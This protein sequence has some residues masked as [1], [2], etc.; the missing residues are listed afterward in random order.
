M[1]TA[2]Y[3]GNV[4]SIG[5]IP[6]NEKIKIELH[7]VHETLLLPLWSRARAAELNCSFLNDTQAGQ[8]IERLDYDFSKFSSKIRKFFIVMLA[9]RAKELDGMVCR[10]IQIHPRAT[11]VNIGA[12]LDTTFYRINNG[13]I[14][15]YDLDVPGVID[16]RQALLEYSPQIHPIPKSMFDPSFLDD[17]ESQKDGILFLVSGVLM[18]FSEQEVQSFLGAIASRFPGSEIVF[19]AVTPFGI[20]VANRVIKKSGISGAKIMWGISNTRSME[21]WEMKLKLKARLPVCCET[22]ISRSFGMCSSIFI[23]LNRLLHIYTL[24]RLKSA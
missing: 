8:L 12:G 16:L 10:F 24:N 19:D 6:N 13:T 4:K 17:I 20:S 3:G 5:L 15:W 7:N 1:D 18:Y 2:E 21:Q 9:A 11:I 22:P 14:K 23:W